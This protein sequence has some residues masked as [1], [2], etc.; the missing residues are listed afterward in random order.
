[1]TRTRKELSPAAKAKI[2]LLANRLK[3]APEEAM[4]LTQTLNDEFAEIVGRSLSVDCEFSGKDTD[5]IF[6]LPKKDTA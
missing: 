1:M 6:T 5:F 4:A 2:I 3:V